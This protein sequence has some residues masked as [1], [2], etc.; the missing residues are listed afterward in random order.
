VICEHLAGLEAELHAAGIA[1]TYRGSPWT[2]NCREW[3]YFACVLDRP[4]LRERLSLPAFVSDHEH[5]GTHDGTEAGFVCD[6]CHDGV[7]GRHPELP[8]DKPV[9][10]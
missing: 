3:V 1:E 9:F 4:S 6:T 10:G 5:Y 2:K 7:V 8:G